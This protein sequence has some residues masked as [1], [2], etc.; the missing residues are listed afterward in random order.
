MK[1]LSAG[2]SFG[3]ARKVEFLELRKVLFCK[4][5]TLFFGPVVTI[6]MVSQNRTD[7]DASE[8]RFCDAFRFRL[9][10]LRVFG[11]MPGTVLCN[12]ITTQITR[13]N[14]QE[15]SVQMADLE[16]RSLVRFA[17]P[18]IPREYSEKSC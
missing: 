18:A 3:S 9:G 17:L 1:S 6:V 12:R 7:F 11:K 13:S 16:H 8:V 5:F 2:L 4:E 10:S 15:L 14:Y